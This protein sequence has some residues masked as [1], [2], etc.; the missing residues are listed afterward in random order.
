MKKSKSKPINHRNSAP[1]RNYWVIVWDRA[2]HCWSTILVEA[3][4]A[5][6]A[7]KEAIRL[8]NAENDYGPNDDGGFLAIGAFDRTE[9][10]N[11]AA[12]LEAFDEGGFRPA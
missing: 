2:T 8:V 10:L 9:L 11:I 12:E 7:E 6:L 4:N 5:G 3:A 1:T